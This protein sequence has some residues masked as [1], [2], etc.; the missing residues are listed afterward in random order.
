VVHT[1]GKEIGDTRFEVARLEAELLH[2][3][4][5]CGHGMDQGT[6]EGDNC[7]VGEGDV[8]YLAKGGY[9]ELLGLETTQ[10]PSL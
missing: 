2:F 3:V 7:A 8:S 5:H 1:F 9:G 4:T 10:L 6:E